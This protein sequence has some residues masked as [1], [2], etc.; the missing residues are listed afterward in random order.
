M[1]IVLGYYDKGNLGDEQYKTSITSLFRK[2]KIKMDI[3]FSNPHDLKELPQTVEMVVCGGGN[4]IDPW[5][6]DKIKILIY[7]FR[8]PVIALSVG[9]GYESTITKYFL[10]CFDAVVLRHRTWLDSVGSLI[11]HHKVSCIPDLGLSLPPQPANKFERP[12]IGIFWASTIAFDGL[13]TALEPFERDFEIVT[14]CM[15]ISD[16]SHEGDKFIN[17]KMRYKQAP[18][19]DWKDLLSDI[20]GLELVIC[21]R[22]HANIFSIVQE[23]PFVCYAATKKSQFL[24]SDFGFCDNVVTKMEDLQRAVSWSLNNRSFLVD[25]IKSVHEYAASVLS[26][27]QIPCFK[28]SLDSI[29]RECEQMLESGSDAEI[30][31]RTALSYTVGSSENKYLWG[32]VENI[33]NKSHSLSDMLNWIVSDYKQVN[34]V[35]LRFLQSSDEFAGVHRSGWEAVTRAMQQLYSHDG[36]LCDLNVDS[37]FHWRHDELLSKGIIPFKQHWVGFIHHTF[38]EDYS[39][40]NTKSLFQNQTFI[41]SLPLCRVLIVLSKYLANQITTELNRL[42]YQNIKV[43]SIHHPTETVYKKFD[44]QTWIKNPLITQV[45][46]WLRNPYSIYA[47][48]LPWGKKQVLE[49]PKMENYIH[50]RKWYIANKCDCPISTSSHGEFGISRQTNSKSTM[51]KFMTK[52]IHE[53]LRAPSFAEVREGEP[54]CDTCKVWPKSLQKRIISITQ[55]LQ[56]NYSSVKRI[57]FLQNDE[58]D[59]LLSTSVVFLDL[60][61]CSAANTV[62][63]CI[64]RNTPIIVNKLEPLEEYL[65]ADYPGF[66]KDIRSVWRVFN[67]TRVYEIN[68]YLQNLD[69]SDLTFETFVEKVRESINS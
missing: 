42:G 28:H 45:G 8:G 22:F 41:N 54:C 7:K 39:P 6:W 43:V 65:G 19:M 5:F 36:I 17:E 50:P 25:K 34:P 26:N 13:E 61:D 23:T 59:K 44:V 68:K 33:K 48:R 12:R 30:V 2:N 16:E 35:K 32:F 51:L 40:Y 20:S 18:C 15:N 57:S 37:T 55:S 4:I 60:I 9:I 3:V 53:V 56:E 63:E 67:P 46:A 24:M 14:Y 11:G 21:S 27:F 62:V 52:Y 31:A 1:I 29:T 58:F 49:G 69:K 66:W 10:S 64:V 47:L 38:I